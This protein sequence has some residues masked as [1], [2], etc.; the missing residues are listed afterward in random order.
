MEYDWIQDCTKR[1]IFRLPVPTL[2]HLSRNLSLFL[3]LSLSLSLSC[4]PALAFY[5]TTAFGNLSRSTSS[6]SFSSSILRTVYAFLALGAIMGVAMFLQAALMESAAAEIARELK[7]QWFQALLR[8]DMAYFDIKNVAG[9]ATTV[10]TNG[11][12]VQSTFCVCNSAAHTSDGCSKQQ[13]K[14][15]SKSLC[16]VSS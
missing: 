13:P 15:T 5:F 3:L 12:K 1:V 14:L 7:Q 6:S 2:S 9:E 8:Q 16:F 11:T 4:S 10:S